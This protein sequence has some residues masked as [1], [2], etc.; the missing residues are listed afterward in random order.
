VTYSCNGFNRLVTLYI[1]RGS[2]LLFKQTIDVHV[3]AVMKDCR[4]GEVIASNTFIIQS[5]WIDKYTSQEGL[6]E[7]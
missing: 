1:N 6:E 5:R 4:V 3:R 2:G 7:S